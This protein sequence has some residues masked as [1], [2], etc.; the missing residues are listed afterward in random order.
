MS[1]HTKHTA[2]RN[3]KQITESR[4]CIKKVFSEMLLDASYS[5]KPDQKYDYRKGFKYI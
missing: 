2:L 4:I 5:K 3:D 1:A